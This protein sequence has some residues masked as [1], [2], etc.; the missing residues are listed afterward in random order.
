MPNDRWMWDATTTLEALGAADV[1]LWVW[2]PERDRIRLTGATRA[3]GLGPLAP[4]CSSAA[5][6]AL[7]LPQD[8]AYAEDILRIQEPGCE[9]AVRLRMRGAGVSIWRGVWLEEGCR[10]AGVVAPETRFAASDQ[11][12]LTGLLDRKSF[13]TPRPRATADAG[14][15]RA[16]RRRPRPPAP[17]ERGSGPRARRPGAGGPG[18]QARRLLPARRHPGQDRRG[19][20][21]RALRGRRSPAPT[22]CAARWNS[23]SA[24]PASTSTRPFPSA[25]WRPRAASTRRRRPN[26]C[27]APNSPWNPPRAMA[28]AARPPMAAAWEA[29]ACR[30]WRWKATSRARWA[31]ANW[32]RSTSRSCG[33]RAA[34]SRASRPWSAG[35]TRAAAC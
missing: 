7:A 3:L 25:P 16:D 20:V 15:A 4:D 5:L 11:D 14:A 13:I 30:A 33:S 29:T 35:A 10:A 23:R 24:S 26:C 8:R 6:R 17:P 31:A 9:V 1:V 21:R 18:L 19:R 28:A 22:P 2:E 32:C 34:R 27:A 12:A